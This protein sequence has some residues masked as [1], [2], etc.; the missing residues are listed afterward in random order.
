MKC[1][2]KEIPI[3]DIVPSGDNARKDIEKS[4]TFPALIESIKSGGVRQVLQVVPHPKKKGRYI[5][6]SGERR[7]RASKA[8]GIKTVPVLIYDGLSDLDAFD[9]TVKAKSGKKAS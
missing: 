6:R 7:Y 4:P 5:L 3:S 9:L 8:A 1:E 2:F